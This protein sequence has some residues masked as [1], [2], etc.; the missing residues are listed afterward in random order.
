MHRNFNWDRVR[1]KNNENTWWWKNNG[2]QKRVRSSQE[3]EASEHRLGSRLLRDQLKCVH[4]HGTRQRSR[5]FWR[6]CWI[7][8]VYRKQRSL[9]F[10]SNTSSSF[11][12]TL[13]WSLSPWYQ[14]IKYIG[15]L[16]WD[17]NQNHRLQHLQVLWKQAV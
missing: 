13:E 4:G 17:P 3:I 11:L 7:R 2:C 10:L 14:A 8:K 5:D 1:C 12:P 9:A 16:M 15:S 6:Y